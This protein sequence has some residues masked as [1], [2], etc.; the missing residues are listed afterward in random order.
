MKTSVSP[1]YKNYFYDPIS[2]F[3]HDCKGDKNGV[4]ETI[5]RNFYIWKERMLKMAL[6]LGL[7]RFFVVEIILEAAYFRD[8]K[9]YE[10]LNMTI[11]EAT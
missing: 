1:P 9:E 2:Q 8:A 3:S 4:K 7:F 10:K 11:V 6:I 5:P